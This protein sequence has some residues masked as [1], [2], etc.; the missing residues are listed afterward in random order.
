MSRRVLVFALF[1]LL[2]AQFFA[3][4]AASVTVKTNKS[5]YYPGDTVKITGTAPAGSQVAIQVKDPSGSTVWVDQVTASGGTFSSTFK[6]RSNAKTGTYKVYASCSAGSASTTFKVV[7]R[8]GPPPPPPGPAP[9]GKEAAEMTL[10]DLEWLLNATDRLLDVLGNIT[11]VSEF[12]D[13]FDDIYDMYNDALIS[14]NSKD[15]GAAYSKASNALRDLEKLWRKAVCGAA[16]DAMELAR[17]LKDSGDSD[18]ILIGET[19]EMLVGLLECQMTSVY[20]PVDEPA[21]GS[22]VLVLALTLKESDVEVALAVYKS[23]TNLKAMADRIKELKSSISDL[24]AKVEALERE[25]SELKKQVEQVK[26]QLEEAKREA[27]KAVEDYK[28]LLS[29][30]EQVKSERDQLADRVS[31]LEQEVARLSEE[32]GAARGAGY[33]YAAVALIVGFIVGVVV[34]KAVLGGERKSES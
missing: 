21:E 31:E 4:S 7:S 30:L 12:R 33:M 18:L 17:R 9:T 19:I 27:E 29:E 32:A 25:R 2:A 10:K 22:G 6:L 15:Y 8:P 14:F 16:S 13:E 11:D 20:V 24:E 28:K 1:L 34:G 26:A 5:E 23:I 3:V